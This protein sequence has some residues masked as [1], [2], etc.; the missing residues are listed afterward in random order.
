MSASLELL[1]FT[2][3]NCLYK[4][5]SDTYS[6]QR[7]LSN[8]TIRQIQTFMGESS[9]HLRMEDDAEWN[10]FIPE[11]GLVR[12]E[13]GQVFTPTMVH[14]IKCINIIRERVIAL[15]RHPELETK[16]VRRHEV[17]NHCVN[18]LRQMLL[19]HG[20]PTVE[21]V[22]GKPAGAHGGLQSCWD[23]EAIYQRLG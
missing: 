2:S 21:I 23:W 16:N 6:F 19:C 4:E 22:F 15:G 18:Y 3:D 12:A 11:N 1:F 14:E 20:D 8:T 17:A 10:A 7:V 13:E 9:V 5:Y